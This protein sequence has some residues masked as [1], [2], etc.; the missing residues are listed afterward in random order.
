VTVILSV[1]ASQSADHESTPWV[2]HET[3][4]CVFLR[5]CFADAISA[6]A[7]I[8]D[9]GIRQWGTGSIVRV[10]VLGILAMVDAGE[11]DWKVIAINVQDPL[12][13]LLNDIDDLHVHLPGCVEAI[14]R[15]LKHYKTPEINTFAFDG[16]IQDRKFAL[17]VIEETHLEWRRLIDERGKS[18]TIAK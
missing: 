8:L 2:L 3:A 13:E 12:A 6:T 7:D 14:H 18:A 1:S 15:W 16:K 11:T 10:K 9:I 17:D 5:H 4:P